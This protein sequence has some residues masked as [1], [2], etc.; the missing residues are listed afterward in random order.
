M[1][2][3]IKKIV[4]NN[5]KKLLDVFRT[6][7]HIFW[8]EEDVRS[9]LYHLLISDKFFQ[10]NMPPHKCEV[11]GD[12]AYDSGKTILVHTQTKFKGK[13][14]DITIFELKEKLDETKEELDT[15]IGIEIKFNRRKHSKKETSN[16]FDD[17]K[18]LEEHKQGYII[19]LN[20][21]REMDTRTIR[22]VKNEVNKYKNVRLVYLD[23]Y[24]N[25]EE[26]LWFP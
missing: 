19:W 8:T 7:P 26:P 15:L 3:E 17:I 12:K 22:D 10:E 5:I 11:Y 21:D 6:N 2:L 25:Q 9:Y 24:S 16:I 20:W 4:E 1:E 18:S 14:E 23:L 13:N